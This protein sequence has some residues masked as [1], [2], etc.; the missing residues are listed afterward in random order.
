MGDTLLKDLRGICIGEVTLQILNKAGF[1]T[2]ENIRSSTHFE[3]AVQTVLDEMKLLDL[4]REV[5]YWRKLG[6]RCTN[7]ANRLKNAIA[8]PAH[9][10][11]LLCG[12]C[13]DLLIDAVVT[14]NGSS[15]C[16]TCIEQW[17]EK[18]ATHPTTR[19]PLN[20]SLL[21]RNLALN[22]AVE[23]YQHNYQCYNVL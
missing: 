6:T 19:E 21:I 7:I 15:F 17:I 13:V 11:H 10:C 9:P 3:R 1:Y 8:L 22:D 16:R 2:V 14:P 20:K 5:T 12:I 18:V 23:H 4:Q